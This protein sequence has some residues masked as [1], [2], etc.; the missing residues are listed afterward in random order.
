[1]KYVAI[2]SALL[3]L[4]PLG[5]PED[6]AASELSDVQYVVAA[7]QPGKFLGWPANN[8]A[9]QWGDH[10]LVGFTQ[11]TFD[12]RDGHN[13]R[14]I[15]HSLFTRSTDGGLTWHAFDPPGF[16]DDDHIKWRPA[17][18]TQLDG[19]IDFVHPGFALRMFATGYHGNDDP[20]GGF[21]YSYDRGATWKGPHLLGEVNRH[22]E[23]QGKQI[24]ARTDYQVVNQSRCMI[25]ISAAMPGGVNRLACLQAVEGGRTFDFVGWITPATDRYSAIMPS[26]IR[27]PDGTYVLAYRKIYVDKTQLESEIE[28][29]RSQDNGSTWQHL[30]TVKEIRENSNPPALTRLEDGRLCCVYGDRDAAKIC[31]KYSSDGGLTWGD[32]F[33]IR[34]GYATGD[35]WPDMGYPRLLKRSDGK[36]VAVYY[37]A[38]PEHPEQYIEA[39]IWQP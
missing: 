23:L 38:S 29:Y 16:L 13:I 12:S 26:T 35:D 20:Q 39:A 37:W 30:S 9:W 36:L 6:A 19:P 4:V 25:F 34:T 8:G 7:R 24:T 32:E 14:G 2:V 27:L 15:Q 3:L 5:A 31:G 10:L 18:K 11:G 17:G 28:V 33:T 22:P 21:Y 1:M